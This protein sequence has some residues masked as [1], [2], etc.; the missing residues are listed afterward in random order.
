MYEKLCYMHRKIGG[1]DIYFYMIPNFRENITSKGPNDEI[2][3]SVGQVTLKK[4]SWCNFPA[5]Y[6]QENTH[7]VL[8]VDRDADIYSVYVTEYTKG[9]NSPLGEEVDKELNRLLKEFQKQYAK[10][11]QEEVRVY[12]YN[13]QTDKLILYYPSSYFVTGSERYKYRLDRLPEVKVY[14]VIDRKFTKPENDCFMFGR[15]KKTIGLRNSKLLDFIEPIY[16][17]I[18]LD[19]EKDIY[20]L[21]QYQIDI[22]GLGKILFELLKVTTLSKTHAKKEEILQAFEK[23]DVNRLRELWRELG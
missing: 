18:P 2:F 21:E 19:F 1:R 5:V 8:C 3:S 15:V 6:V 7:W 20:D 14:S 22:N 11:K 9:I 4:R 16:K 23:G 13:S 10:A 17:L 12:F